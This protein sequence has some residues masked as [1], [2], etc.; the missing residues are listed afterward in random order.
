MLPLKT[1]FF[2]LLGINFL[3]LITLMISSR[4]LPKNTAPES[5]K[6][7]PSCYFQY[8]FSNPV[9]AYHLIKQLEVHDPI[10]N[11]HYN[12]RIQI[13]PVANSTFFGIIKEKNYCDHHLKYFISHPETTFFGVNFFSDYLGSSMVRQKI[14]NQIGYDLYPQSKYGMT[15]EDKRKMHVRLDPSMSMFFVNSDPNPFLTL[16]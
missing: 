2:V 8:K 11:H 15:P 14:L 13:G 16:E 4:N 10:P 6:N 7:C 9:A 1:L 3:G 12:N 5:A